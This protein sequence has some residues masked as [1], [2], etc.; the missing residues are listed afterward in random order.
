[1]ANYLF[2]NALRSRSSRFSFWPSFCFIFFLKW[3]ESHSADLKVFCYY[4]PFY[5]SSFWFPEVPPTCAMRSRSK[6]FFFFSCW[7]IWHLRRTCPPSVSCV[8]FGFFPL[9]YLNP[10]LIVLHTS[11]ISSLLAVSKDPN[12]AFFLHW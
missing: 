4:S 3:V 12:S 10:F 8:L 5:T 9:S 2:Q 6:F 11:G 7:I 1:M